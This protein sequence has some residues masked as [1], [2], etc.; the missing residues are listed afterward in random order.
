MYNPRTPDTQA[1]Y[2][3]FVKEQRENRHEFDISKMKVVTEYTHWQIIKNP[4][5]YDAMTRINDLLISK[6]T[7]GSF[8]DLDE[9]E[10]TEYTS[11]LADIA[12]HGTYDALIENFPKTKTIKRHLHIHLVCWHTTATSS[13]QKTK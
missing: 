11:I 3:A 7:V 13:L 2:E 1:A 8:A 5:P 12:E 6:R 4:F 9:S 10:T